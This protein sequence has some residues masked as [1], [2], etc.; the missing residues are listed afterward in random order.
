M[1]KKGSFFIYLMAAA[2]TKMVVSFTF[3]VGGMLQHKAAI[4]TGTFIS[5]LNGCQGLSG[6]EGLI[7]LSQLSIGPLSQDRETLLESV[8]KILLQPLYLYK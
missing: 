4:T 5:H 8:G 6:H 7:T 3:Q 1:Q 2:Y